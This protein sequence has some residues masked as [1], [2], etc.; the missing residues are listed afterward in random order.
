VT[1]R[2]ELDTRE[3]DGNSVSG[4]RLSRIVRLPDV[5]DDEL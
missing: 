4:L 2:S 3:S 1:C 5:L